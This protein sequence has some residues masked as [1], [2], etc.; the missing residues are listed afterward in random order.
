MEEEWSDWS[1]THG[2]CSVIYYMTKWDLFQVCKVGSTLKKSLNL[3]S[4]AKEGIPYDQ[5]NWLT[6]NTWHNPTPIQDK[7]SQQAS[8]RV[9]LPWLDNEHLQKSTA[10]VIHNG[11]RPDTF[12]PKIGNKV[13][14]SSLTTPFQHHKIGPC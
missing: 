7:N 13:R 2:S 3:V 9:D 6:K 5:V 11:E 10:P 4:H 8:N 12:S 1:H 14:M